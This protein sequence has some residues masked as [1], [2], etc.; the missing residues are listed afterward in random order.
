[1]TKKRGFAVPSMATTF[2][3]MVVGAA[4]ASLVLACATPPSKYW[5]RG[6]ST[7]KDFKLASR[8]CTERAEDEGANVSSSSCT[9]TTAY[10][11]GTYCQ[12]EDPDSFD[13][14]QRRQVKVQRVYAQ[15]LEKRGWKSNSEGEGFEG[16]Y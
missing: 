11:G 1:M 3:L 12:Q 2:G 10:G 7:E 16:V 9:T 13:N 14:R 6:K 15:C 5:T 4:L 8:W